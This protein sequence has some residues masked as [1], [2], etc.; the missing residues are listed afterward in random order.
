MTQQYLGQISVFGFNFAP[1]GWAQCQGQI[2]AISQYTALFSLIGTYYG[3][4]GTSN[5]AL[6]NFQGNIGVGI[7]QGAGLSNYDIGETTGT[8]TVTLQYSQMPFHNHPFVASTTVGTT[9]SSANNQLAKAATGGKKGSVTANYLNTGAPTTSLNPLSLST[10]GGN[11]SH[12]NLQPY[13]AV[14]YCIA[15]KGT[16]PARN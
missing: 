11:Q 14:N 7:G 10:V 9:T 13:M 2:L 12:Q 8:P 5:F 15:L 1:A 6:P 4:N 3:G 16:Y